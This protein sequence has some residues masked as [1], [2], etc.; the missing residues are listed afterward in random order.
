MGR[1]SCIAITLLSGFLSFGP[2]GTAG[3]GGTLASAGDS[4]ERP[5]DA[6]VDKTKWPASITAAAGAVR[7]RVDGPKLWTLSRIE[8]GGSLLGVEESAYGTAVNIRNVGF[9]GSAHRLD[10]PGRPGEIEEEQVLRLQIRADGRPV[11]KI[12]SD[13]VKSDDVVVCQTFRMERESTIRSL[14]L[15]SLLVVQ[16]ERVTETV[17]ICGS[18]DMELKVLYPLMY[19]WSSTV[20]EWMMSDCRN[21]IS[22]GQF[23]RQVQETASVISRK[24]ARWAAVYDPD[25]RTGAVCLVTAP[26][27]LEHSLQFIDAP[28]VYRKLYVVAFSDSTLPAGFNGT[29]SVITGFFRASKVDWMRESQ[30][31]A[32]QLSG[33]S[34]P[35]QSDR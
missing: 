34:V 15:R 27:D 28:G 23:D 31:V 35:E 24:S 18:E 29:F 2:E 7:I 12:T 26:E 13:D 20:T 22:T 6:V 14:S 17:R 19:A 10:V 4:V 8:Y 1:Y 11:H 32:D 25:A 3:G 33:L 21:D 30:T 9:L 5:K 16:D